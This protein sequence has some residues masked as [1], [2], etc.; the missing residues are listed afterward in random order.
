MR[1][2]IWGASLFCVAVAACSMGP[3]VPTEKQVR[4]DLIGGSLGYQANSGNYE[5][6]IT[7]DNL[8]E[9]VFQQRYTDR[10]AGTDEIHAF[11]TID[12][13]TTAIKGNVVLSYKMYDQ[14]WKL[15]GSKVGA[16]ERTVQCNREG[17]GCNWYDAMAYCKNNGTRLASA[18][19]LKNIYKTECTGKEAEKCN[20][21]IYW[22]SSVPE[23]MAEWLSAPAVLDRYSSY[24]DAAWAVFFYPKKGAMVVGTKRADKAHARC[25]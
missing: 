18:E 12:D 22:S 9:V 2:V 11:L 19:E 8:K 10:K 17:L 14:G 7:K 3:S 13:G 21:T 23:T 24:T 16:F 15:E 6:S 20:E 1:K 25:I 5:C 4:L